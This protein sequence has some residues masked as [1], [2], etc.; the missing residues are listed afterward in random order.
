MRVVDRHIRFNREKQ[1]FDHEKLEKLRALA[2]E[3][4]TLLMKQGI[5]GAFPST[6]QHGTE[7]PSVPRIPL[8]ALASI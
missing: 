3:H 7:Y 2:F 4:Q 6:R 1:Q 5:P 8:A